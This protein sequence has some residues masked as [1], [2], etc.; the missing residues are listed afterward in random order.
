MK[1][2]PFRKT[3]QG[4][5]N[6]IKGEIFNKKFKAYLSDDNKNLN[7]KILNTGIKADFNFDKINKM[8]TISG[9]SKITILNNYIFLLNQLSILFLRFY[10][11]FSGIM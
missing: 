8:G 3:Y 7:F 10:C 5:K 4:E 1:Y 11:Y 6:R 9:S 2:G